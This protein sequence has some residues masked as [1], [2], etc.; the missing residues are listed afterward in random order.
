MEPSYV[1]TQYKYD[2][3]NKDELSFEKGV[4]LRI[5]NKGAQNDWW[6][7]ALNESNS[8][9]GLV[10]K[11][12]LQEINL[13]ENSNSQVRSKQD[14]VKT[15]KLNRKLNEPNLRKVKKF[16]SHLE[17]DEYVPMESHKLS[18]ANYA[19]DTK[20][21]DFANNEYVKME[22][23]Y[24]EENNDYVGMQNGTGA[25]NEN[26]EYIPINTANQF[27]EDNGYD[28]LQNKDGYTPVK[29]LTYGGYKNGTTK[30]SRD[31]QG[32]KEGDE[33]DPYSHAHELEPPAS[34]PPSYQGEPYF[35][36]NINKEQSEILL[37][38]TDEGTFLIRK[39]QSQVNKN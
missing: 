16:Q 20:K 29:T 11:N 18:A 7:L 3:R 12:H 26:N 15:R 33:Q 8:Q 10:P 17:D 36:G 24:P 23:V 38:G 22:K 13:P 27:V 6:W 19:K 21:E 28:R 32:N 30:K 9:K 34:L 31:V 2:A 25:L 5:L 39:S 35:Y 4:V 1:R 14:E 37:S